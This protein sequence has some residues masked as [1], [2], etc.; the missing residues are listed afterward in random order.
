MRRLPFFSPPPSRLVAWEGVSQLDGVT[1][2]RVILTG[3]GDMSHNPKTGAMVQ[4]WVVLRDMAPHEATRTGDDSAVCGDCP[5]RPSADRKGALPCYVR[6][7][8][9]PRSTWQAAQGESADLDRALRALRASGRALRLG[10][11]GDPAAVPVDVIRALCNAAPA[12]TGYTHQWRRDVARELR[13]FVMASADSAKDRDDAHALGWRTFR[14]I[15][16]RD[17]FHELQGEVYCPAI[18]HGVTCAQ[19]RLCDGAHEHD[20]RRSIAIVEH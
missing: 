13:S 16:R 19:C 18:T 1:P 8:Q 15:D 14:A 20:K 5:K 2:I 7:F 17:V 6:A 4:A 3:L 10:A 12:H 9:G 11:Y